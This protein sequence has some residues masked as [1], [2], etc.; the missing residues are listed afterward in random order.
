[1]NSAT[2]FLIQKERMKKKT[3]GV[4]D[5]NFTAYKSNIRTLSMHLYKIL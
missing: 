3:Q 2:E 1:M 5:Y 4:N